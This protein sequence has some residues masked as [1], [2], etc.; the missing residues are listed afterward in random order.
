MPKIYIAGAHSR[1]QTVAHYL[2]YLDNTTE[3]IAYLYDNDEDNPTEVNG[4]PVIKIS[5]DTLL[6][7]SCR[8]FLGVR[9]VNMEHLSNTLTQCGMKDI[10]PVD[11]KLDMKLRN[12]Y[13]EKYYDEQGIDSLRMDMLRSDGSVSHDI[14]G[15]IFVANSVF[16]GKLSDVYE[17][18]NE[19]SIL[20][21]GSTLTDN[22]IEGCEF[23]DN[24][25]DNISGLNKQFCELTGLYWVW[26]NATEDYVGLVHY[27]R[28]FL[29]P[30]DWIS[31]CASN[32]V[33]VILPVPL[34]VGSSVEENYRMRHVSE[35]WDFVMDFI[36][37]NHEEEYEDVV[38]F[39]E[40]SLYCPCNMM[41]AK[42]EVLDELCSWM[43][44][45]VFALYEH[46]GVHEDSY[47]NRYPGFVSE[48]LITYFFESRRDKYNLV[49]C[50]KN[51]L[52]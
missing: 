51:F 6:D 15:R 26:K 1:A 36:Q 48:R 8:V 32:D 46:V 47:Q 33:D 24:N 16:D 27:R 49:Y 38:T 11:A 4:I 19:E 31:V 50:N 29:L 9:G 14:S 20:Q 35:D 5:G 25:G 7:T 18:I 13:L 34:Y 21:V 28:H 39:F 3:I 23:F 44:P 40:G 37:K 52:N 41:I 30:K 42:K 45:I 2:T 12:E 10:V 17:M 22:R 43:F